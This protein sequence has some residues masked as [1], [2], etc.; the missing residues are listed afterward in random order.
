MFQCLRE[1]KI[2]VITGASMFTHSLSSEVGSGSRSH[3]LSGD[4]RISLI[5]SYGVTEVKRSKT[6]G[7]DGGSACGDE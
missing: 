7:M 5:I 1:I 4:F 2:V 3:C 6:G